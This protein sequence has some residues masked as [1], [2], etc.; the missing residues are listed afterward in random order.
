MDVREAVPS[1]QVCCCA[2]RQGHKVATSWQVHCRGVQLSCIGSPFQLCWNHSRVFIGR[3]GL[4][5]AAAP[6]QEFFGDFIALDGHHFAIPIARPACL[7]QPFAWDFAS[8][9][10]AVSRM[11]E[12]LA[13]LALS[14]RRR[15]QIRWAAAEPA[16]TPQGYRFSGIREPRAHRIS[17]MA[18]RLVHSAVVWQASTAC[19]ARRGNRSSN[20]STETRQ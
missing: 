13:A 16:Q 9:S 17:A 14:L 3:L 11:T 4:A 15:F 8:S 6:L 19:V 1:V 7:L 2:P 20:C 12:G 10:D 18:A 5:E